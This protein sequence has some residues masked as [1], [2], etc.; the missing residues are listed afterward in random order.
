MVRAKYNT[1]RNKGVYLLRDS[2]KSLLNQRD[3]NEFWKTL[4]LL[5]HN[6][7][8]ISI[9]EDNGTNIVTSTDKA[10]VLNRFFY[11][12]FNNSCAPLSECSLVSGSEAEQCPQYL[13]STE[14]SLFELLTAPDISRRAVTEY[15]RK[16]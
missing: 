13:L 14:E 7:S 5:N 6:P 15:H 10:N 11:S 8:T 4:K 16:C 12:C 9:L 3:T 2:K 1:R